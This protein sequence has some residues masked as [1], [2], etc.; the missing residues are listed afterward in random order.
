MNRPQQVRQVFIELRR[1]TSG[2]VAAGELL[3]CANQLVDAFYGDDEPRFELRLGGRPFDEW[4][5]DTVFSDGGWRVLDRYQVESFDGDEEAV[6][7]PLLVRQFKEFGLEM[8][9]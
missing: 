9:A 7:D 4:A 3:D 2:S 8:C 1:A 6:N 5:L